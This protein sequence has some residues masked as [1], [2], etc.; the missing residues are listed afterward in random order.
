MTSWKWRKNKETDGDMDREI[1]LLTSGKN[2]ECKY[3]FLYCLQIFGL[4]KVKIV[5]MTIK[6]KSIY[7]GN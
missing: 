6:Q 2:I 4:R 1:I 7:K 3:G 5:F